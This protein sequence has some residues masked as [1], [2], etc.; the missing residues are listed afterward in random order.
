MFRTSLKLEAGNPETERAG[1]LARVLKQ[2]GPPRRDSGL[3]RVPSDTYT[4]MTPGKI[5]KSE[6]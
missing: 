4:R 5:Q 2:E 1:S 3:E 6:F